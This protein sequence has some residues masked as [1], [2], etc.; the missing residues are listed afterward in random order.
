MFVI[1]HRNGKLA[2]K[3]LYPTQEAAEKDAAPSGKLVAPVTIGKGIVPDSPYR[4]LFAFLKTEGIERRSYKGRFWEAYLPLGRFPRLDKIA[5][6]DMDSPTH[7][8]ITWDSKDRWSVSQM[9]R[10][11]KPESWRFMSDVQMR[12]DL[13]KLIEFLR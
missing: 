12:D 11:E 6:G 9:E 3:K 5:A 4:D 10:I 1:L 8:R 7:T 13:T 2:K